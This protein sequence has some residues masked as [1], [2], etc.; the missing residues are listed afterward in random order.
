M[1]AV[2]G[3]YGCVRIG[4]SVVTENDQWS[5]S[6]QCVVHQY[7]TCS[8][9]GNTGT[10]ALAGRRKHSGSMGGI[11]CDDDPIENYFNEG[12][13]VVLK[14]YWTAQRWYEGTAIIENLDIEEVD[15]T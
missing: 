9:P 1:T 8:T 10:A 5:L 7:A 2:S 11:Q 6:R 4:S 15:I 12:D 14:L 3:Q 13:S